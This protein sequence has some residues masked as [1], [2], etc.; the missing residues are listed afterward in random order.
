[1]CALFGTQASLFRLYLIHSGVTKTQVVCRSRASVQIVVSCV[2]VHVHL[3]TFA[4][5]TT[6]VKRFKLHS[7]I[8]SCSHSKLL[9]SVTF[10][11]LSIV[12]ETGLSGRG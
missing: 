7:N 10:L 12:Y 11:N 3:R 4:S 2:E 8:M 1:M 5:K 9:F 6:Q